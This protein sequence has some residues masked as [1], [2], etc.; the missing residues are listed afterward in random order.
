[1][2]DRPT[3]KE[4]AEALDIGEAEAFTY[5]MLCSAQVKPNVWKLQFAPETPAPVRKKIKGFTKSFTC[6][7][8][9]PPRR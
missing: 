1:M 3:T 5:V 8:A 9:I 7:V 4:I 6:I 2:P